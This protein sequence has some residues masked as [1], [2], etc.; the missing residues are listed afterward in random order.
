MGCLLSQ[1]CWDE[2]LGPNR[3]DRHSSRVSHSATDSFRVKNSNLSLVF[4]AKGY[5][6]PL[7]T[8]RA[9]LKR[10]F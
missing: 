2:N 8:E 4:Q 1:C 6:S 10:L 3:S 5:L 7:V 9:E